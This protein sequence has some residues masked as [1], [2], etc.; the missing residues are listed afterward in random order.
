MECTFCNNECESRCDE[1][2]DLLC[3]E[4]ASVVPTDEGIPWRMCCECIEVEKLAASP[5]PWPQHEQE[6]DD[7]VNLES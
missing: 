1:C 7:E 6:A 5:K 3:D 4:C 2:N